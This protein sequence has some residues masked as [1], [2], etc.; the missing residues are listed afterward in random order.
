MDIRRLVIKGPAVAS[1]F[2]LVRERLA[3][4]GFDR[5]AYSNGNVSFFILEKY[6][7]NL[8]VTLLSIMIFD[9]G[10]EGKCKVEI[11][12]TEHSAD[13]LDDS[14]LWSAEKKGE[15]ALVKFLEELCGEKSWKMSEE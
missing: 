7:V 5:Y 3:K 8:K 14:W 4:E 12:S 10:K 1:L 13:I 11:I 2:D 9:F 15:N 6:Y